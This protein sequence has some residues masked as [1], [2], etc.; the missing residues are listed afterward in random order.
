MILFKFI[1]THKHPK[2]NKKDSLNFYTACVDMYVLRN[3]MAQTLA[4]LRLFSVAILC[5]GTVFPVPPTATVSVISWYH[6]TLT[7]KR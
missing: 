3:W 1:I 4:C 7:E 6:D 2:F 5:Q